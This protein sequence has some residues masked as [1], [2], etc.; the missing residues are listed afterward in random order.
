M[1]R[2]PWISTSPWRG[3]ASAPEGDTHGAPAPETT[4]ARQGDGPLAFKSSDLPLAAGGDSTFVVDDIG[5]GLLLLNP[6]VD[7]VGRRALPRLTSGTRT[8]I[9]EVRGGDVAGRFYCPGFRPNANPTA[10]R[11]SA[12]LLRWTPATDAIDTLTWV[13]IPVQL[14]NGARTVGFGAGA[15]YVTKPV[16]NGRYEVRKGRW[17][18]R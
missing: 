11:D 13:R 18:G 16:E 6:S 5:A 9:T 10:P 12:P 7:A 4:L 2:S 15:V 3:S 17:S 14:A 1:T 8:L